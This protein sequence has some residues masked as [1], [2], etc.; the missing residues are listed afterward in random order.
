MT[1]ITRHA[2]AERQMDD[3]APTFEAELFSHP[4]RRGAI[5][6]EGLRR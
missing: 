6:V 4:L 3:Y 2:E 5:G 1:V